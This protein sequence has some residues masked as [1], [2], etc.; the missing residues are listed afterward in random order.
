M[1]IYFFFQVELDISQV[2]REVY[3][4][5]TAEFIELVKEFLSQKLRIKHDYHL[6]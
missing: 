2:D 4:E 5:T 6:L 3:D 1:N